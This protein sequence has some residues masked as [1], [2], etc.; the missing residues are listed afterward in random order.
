MIIK[1]WIYAYKVCKKYKIKWNIFRNLDNA[2]FS[3]TDRNSTKEK[4]VIWM[5]PFYPK[6]RQTFLHEVGHIVFWRSGITPRVYALSNKLCLKMEA[7][8]V[9]LDGKRLIPR[10]IE[11]T[12]ASR[13]ARKAMRGKADIEDLT[14]AFKT[15]SAFGYRTLLKNTPTDARVIVN[16]TDVVY[17]CLKRIEK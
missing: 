6:F 14:E 9:W 7:E 8:S 2:S 13:F 15:Y 16:L 12:R 17:G 10:L 5:N 3:I 1:D 11:E 4:A